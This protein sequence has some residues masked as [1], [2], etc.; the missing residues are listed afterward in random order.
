M[1]HALPAVIVAS[2]M[3]PCQAFAQAEIIA[4]TASSS[5]TGIPTF[6]FQLVVAGIVFMLI[7]Y[8]LRISKDDA[9]IKQLQKDIK[10]ALQ[11]GDLAIWTFDVDT[12]VVKII[13]QDGTLDL[14]LSSEEFYSSIHPDD[15]KLMH[16]IRDN[17]RKGVVNKDKI[18]IRFGKP[19][20]WRWY[21][22]SFMV[23]DSNKGRFVTGIRRDVTE[24]V[25]N[26][27]KLED[28]NKQNW[29]ILN[30]IT[31]AIVYMDSDYRVQWSNF[32][33][34]FG[35]PIDCNL[36]NNGERCFC[37]FNRDTPCEECSVAKAAKSGGT[38]RYQFCAGGKSFL[39][40]SKC[41]DNGNGTHGYVTRIDDIT[42]QVRMIDDLREAKKRAEE[43]DK[44]KSAFLA[45]MS[46][47]IRTPLNAIVGFSELLQY[48]EDTKERE[49]YIKIINSNNQLLLRLVNDVLDLSKIES[50]T[51]DLC[52]GS[53]DA[54]NAADE[55]YTTFKQRFTDNNV[56]LILDSDFI[57]CNVMLD[58]NRFC[59][60]VTNFLTNALKYTPSGSVT[61]S[62]KKVDG[63]VR[64]SVSDTGIGI[65]AEKQHLVFQ[66]FEKLDSFAQGTGLGLSIS[67]AIVDAMDGK[68]GFSSEAGE[69]STFWAWFPYDITTSEIRN[70]VVIMKTVDEPESVTL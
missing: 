31:S 57:I 30:N 59:Q 32:N 13:H 27:N 46:H 41:V 26:K 17:V 53:F 65:A 14:D 33:S 28:I 11:A 45:N 8:V 50:G 54:V 60:V 47:E 61:L 3:M 58:R 12:C 34:L 51:V 43:S 18:M 67:K 7:I 6:L 19:G 24:K 4:G 23:N 22:C 10:M 52:Y 39:A 38:G 55:L 29:I 40:T 37:S 25:N 69:G 64:V 16:E 66:R 49:E 42:S 5:I 63:G 15:H 1:R 62:L 56:E 20:E 68:I 2:M 9:H 21:E 35:K 44:M 48:T 36:Y 70:D